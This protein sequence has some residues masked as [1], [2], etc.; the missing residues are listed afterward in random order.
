MNRFRS[1]QRALLELIRA[2]ASRRSALI[3]AIV[4]GV[5]FLGSWAAI[6]HGF[7]TEKRIVDTPLYQHYGDWMLGGNVPYRDFS[8]EYP[9]GALPAFALPAIGNSEQV[10]LDSADGRGYALRGDF[11]RNFELLMVLCG[12]ATIAFATVSLRCLSASNGSVAAG[13][14]LVALTPLMLGSVVLS[15]F[16]LWPTMIAAGAVAALLVGWSWIG[17]GLLGA[18][19]VAK[20]FP[21][22]LV[23]LA[24]IWIWKRQ[25]WKE[26]AW[27]AGIFCAVLAAFFAPF[28]IVAPSGVLDSLTEQLGRPLQIESLGAASLVGL[29][30]MF[31]FGLAMENSSGS[32]N[33]SGDAATVVAIAQSSLQAAA[34]GAIWTWFALGEMSRERFVRAA[35]AA[36]VA[37][38]A[39]GK[40]LSPQFLIWLVPFV[41]LVRGRRGLA[42]SALVG[43]SLAVTQLWFPFRYWDYVNDFDALPTALVFL[44]D[45][46][47][48]GALGALLFSWRPVEEESTEEE[49]AEGA[50]PL[51]P[52]KSAA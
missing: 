26:L 30:D 47:L 4:A 24:A 17:F 35:A 3:L 40:V 41:I 32:Q 16:D 48:I 29:H 11:R 46:L 42:A 18:A 25:G 50:G 14:G 33:L 1:I 38:V 43:L 37:F 44:R 12:L 22:V 13:L 39:L 10:G 52:A 49:D 7:Y 28:V 15:R 6:H 2:E 23:P 36:L 20:I 34:L 45:L 31:G 5:L 51:E 27:G 9:P 19:T 21:V 8:V